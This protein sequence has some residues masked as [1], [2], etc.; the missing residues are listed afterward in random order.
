MPVTLS[1][2]IIYTKL[3]FTKPLAFNITLSRTYRWQTENQADQT[4]FLE[5]LVRLFRVVTSGSPLQLEGLVVP[6][7][8]TGRQTPQTSD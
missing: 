8:S 6:D 5:A 3:S 2:I 1:V 7:E 4:S